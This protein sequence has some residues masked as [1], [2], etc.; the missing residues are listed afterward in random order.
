MRL[1]V[2]WPVLILLSVPD[3]AVLYWEPGAPSYE[4]EEE[5]SARLQDLE[6]EALANHQ[7]L[8]GVRQLNSGD[9]PRMDFS[10]ECITIPPRQLHEMMS[11]QRGP[12]SRT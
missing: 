3:V 12:G 1:L 8:A 9:L 11:R 7:F 6:R 10:R 5:C 2:F 4:T